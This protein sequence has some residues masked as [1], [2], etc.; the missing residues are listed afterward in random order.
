MASQ[1]FV[2]PQTA[3]QLTTSLNSIVVLASS[4]VAFLIVAALLSRYFQMLPVVRSLMLET[5]DAYAATDSVEARRP[6]NRR[7]PLIPSSASPFRS[8]TGASL[9]LP[10]ALLAKPGSASTS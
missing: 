3:L 6:A 2:I 10:C 8:A 4:G 5:P 1:H 9:I 7:R